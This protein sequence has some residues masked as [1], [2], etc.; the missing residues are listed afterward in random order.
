LQVRNVSA[1]FVINIYLQ[2]DSLIYN[3]LRHKKTGAEAPVFE[4]RILLRR[5]CLS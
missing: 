1:L 2:T 3:L 4:F 5:C